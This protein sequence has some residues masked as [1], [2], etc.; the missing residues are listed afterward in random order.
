MGIQFGFSRNLEAAIEADLARKMVLLAGP[1][2]VGKTTLARGLA[3]R[4]G[5]QYLLYDD[6]ADREQILRRGAGRRSG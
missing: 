4:M 1:R 5:G 3:L 2:Q 6:P